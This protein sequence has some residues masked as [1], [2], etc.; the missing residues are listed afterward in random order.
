MEGALATA[1]LGAELG[2]IQ[3][4]VAA[5]LLAMNAQAAAAATID[6]HTGAK[7]DVTV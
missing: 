3:L 7:V 5:K 2:R 1:F 4:A 6:L